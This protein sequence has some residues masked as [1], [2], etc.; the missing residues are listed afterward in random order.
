MDVLR[1]FLDDDEVR[2]IQHLLADTTL[3]LR[4]GSTT[5]NPFTSNLGT[6][7]DDSLSPV[8][9]I[10]YLEAALRDLTDS[11]DV[12][13]AFLDNMIVYADDANF[14]CRTVEATAFIQD[15]S[16]AILARWSLA[17]N[18]SKTELTT[19]ARA[20]T[21]TPTR[22]VRAQEEAWRNT[23]K[24]GS[25]L[26]DAED[27]SRRKQL[28]RAALN[29]MWALWLRTSQTSERTRVRLGTCS[30]LGA[31]IADNF[32]KY[33]ASATLGGSPTQR[34]TSAVTPDLC[35]TAS[36]RH[37]EYSLDRFFAA[38]IA[39]QRSCK[40]IATS[41]A[42]LKVAGEDALAPRYQ[43]SWIKTFAT[44]S[45]DAGSAPNPTFSRFVP[46]H[47]TQ[48]RGRNSWGK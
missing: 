11:L 5:L 33:L 46:K 25:L 31:F 18:S 9:F 45:E 32:A 27:V 39:T 34:S 10:V 14:V 38:R 30:A 29:R 44:P 37:D 26:G 48:L 41:I 21:S 43:R 3:S 23:K 40:W 8:L 19:V 47:K 7:Q 2:L 17:M 4:S 36:P 24:L 28:A 16:P 20:S 15:Q 13:R 12:G 35:A 6:P 22:H 42:L 1:S